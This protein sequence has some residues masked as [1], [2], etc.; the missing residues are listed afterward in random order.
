MKTWRGFSVRLEEAVASCFSLDGL[1]IRSSDIAAGYVDVNGACWR[2]QRR[3][4]IIPTS[5]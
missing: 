1:N 2:G 4:E 5:L 3:L